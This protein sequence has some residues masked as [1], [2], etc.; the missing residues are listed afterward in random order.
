MLF[1]GP[2]S[3]MKDPQKAGLIVNW[4]SRQCAMTLHSM[5]VS[6]YKPETVFETLEYIFRP[7]SNQT[8]SRF[9]FRGLKQCQSQSCDTYMAELHLNIVECKYPN[10]V[11]DELLK[12]QFI[13]GV[14]V[15]EV[16]DHFLGEIT[17]EDNSD[18]CLFKAHKV[19]SKIE[20]CKLLGI[21]TSMTYDVIH[22][23]NR[24]RSKSKSKNQ[25]CV[26][27]QSSIRNCKYCGKSHDQGSCPAFGKECT[28]CGKKNH[29]KAVCKS[30]SSDKHDQSRSRPKK[31]KKGKKFHEINAS[32]D[33][34]MDDLADQVQSLFYHDVHFNNVNMRMHTELGC[35][36]SQNKLKQVFKI[37]TGADGNLI[38]ITMFMKLYP[39]ISLEM[40]A[41]TIDKGITLFAYNNTPIKQYGTCSVKITFNG[42]QEICKFY[43]VEHATAILGVSDSEKLGLVK[44]NFDVIQSKTVK[45]VH[46]ISL[47]EV[48]KHEMESEYPE[49]FKG[50]GCM[51]GEISIKLKESAIPH[52][53]MCIMQCK[54]LLKQN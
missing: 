2:L 37:D 23:S 42:K 11:Q 6:L 52:V 25:G 40:L 22:S 14:C 27:S 3:E 39:K 51:D 16:Q 17:P 15:K 20:Q 49:L 43:V 54:N 30:G 53:G 29:F 12:D 31:G 1:Q 44:V 5:N 28:K 36:M 41:K 34:G 4:I 19:E 8:L 32:E 10:T 46:N 24:G 33:N 18:K 50:I 21:K 48:F 13:F 9:K 35:Q 7:E 47:S 26:R 45:M 38:P